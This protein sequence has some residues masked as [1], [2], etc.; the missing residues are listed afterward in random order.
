MAGMLCHYHRWTVT[1]RHYCI[2]DVALGEE[3]TAVQREVK[4]S[5]N[6]RRMQEERKGPTVFQLNSVCVALIPAARAAAAMDEA[7]RRLPWKQSPVSTIRTQQQHHHHL[8]S[9]SLAALVWPRAPSP[10]SAFALLMSE[11]SCWSACAM[12]HMRLIDRSA[13]VEPTCLFTCCGGARSVEDGLWIWLMCLYLVF[14][15][16]FIS[17]TISVLFLTIPMS[18]KYRPVGMGMKPNRIPTSFGLSTR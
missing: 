9:A 8:R 1:T 4:K 3:K 17:S 12:E 16:I 15:F 6:Q 14:I 7:P 10:C 18:T 11:W 2:S 13:V 5:D